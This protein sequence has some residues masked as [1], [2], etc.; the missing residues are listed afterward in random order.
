MHEPGRVHA[1]ADEAPRVK[2]DSP[3]TTG[4]GQDEQQVYPTHKVPMGRNES[5]KGVWH[6]Q[7]LAVGTYCNGKGNQR[8]RARGGQLPAPWQL[9]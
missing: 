3:K 6:S 4:A 9:C 5:G 8:R 7:N 2:S 1:I